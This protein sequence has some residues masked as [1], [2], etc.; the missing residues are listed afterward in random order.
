[1]KKILTL[2]DLVAFCESRK[3]TRF[4]SSES[5]MSLRVRVP[6]VFA[7]YKSDDYTLYGDVKIMHTGRNRNRSNLTLDAMN[8]CKD[9]LAY[10]PLLANFC[11]IDGVKDFTSHDFTVDDNGELQYEEFQIG[12]FTVDEPR[13]EYDKKK[14]RYYLYAL[15][16][17]SR[18]YTDAAEIIE[19]KGGTKVSA[20]LAI[21]EMSYDSKEKE[22]V[23]EDV[24][25]VGVTCLGTDPE[26]GEAVEEGMEGARLDIADFS[27]EGRPTY[28]I[29]HSKEMLN[30]YKKV[31]THTLQK[32]ESMGDE[33]QN[34]NPEETEATTEAVAENTSA[35]ASTGEA[36][37]NAEATATE[38]EAEAASTETTAGAEAEAT[39]AETTTAEAASAEESTEAEGAETESTETEPEKTESE[40]AGE[41]AGAPAEATSESESEGSASEGSEPTAE[42]AVEGNVEFSAKIGG[43]I[44]TFRTSLQDELYALTQLVNDTYAEADNA[45]YVVDAYTDTKEVIMVDYWTGKAYKQA[46]KVRNGVYSLKGDRVSVHARYITDDEEKALD[47]LK[48]SYAAVSDKLKKYEEEPKKMEILNSSDYGYVADTK[49]FV[50]LKDQ[51]NH[52]DLSIAETKAKADEILLAAAKN[53][54]FAKAPEK[55][56]G[57]VGVVRTMPKASKGVGRYGSMFVK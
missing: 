32:G 46:Y 11:E 51:K 33:N 39:E 26:T 7:K 48:S 38:P 10:K 1:M 12:C 4:S 6:A 19:R 21:N 24:E 36:E 53:A 15:C 56:P 43:E 47:E 3:L 50:E 57:E 44:Y 42:S 55:L 37:T 20:E 9:R 49:E 14:D 45:Y 23:L 35:E 5:G 2:D 22:L 41:D 25:V 29:E 34:L 31:E 52:F 30:K 8:K 13:V 27:S 40:G 17:I 54:Q 16:A 18:E 28:D